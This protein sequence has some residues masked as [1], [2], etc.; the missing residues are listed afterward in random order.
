[1]SRLN[2]IFFT[3]LLISLSLCI[4]QYRTLTLR[5]NFSCT[6]LSA[7]QGD[8]SLI[9]YR[10][11]AI[12][13]DGGEEKNKYS[14]KIMNYLS[15]RHINRI[16]LMVV[17]HAHADHLYGILEVIREIPVD[18]LLIPE[19]EHSTELYQNFKEILQKSSIRVLTAVR[20][21]TLHFTPPL[22]LKVLSPPTPSPFKDIDNNSCVIKINYG[23]TSF[24]FTGD[25]FFEAEQWLCENTKKELK[26]DFL[27]VAHHGS[28]TSSSQAFLKMVNPKVAVISCGI[29]NKFRFPHE[30]A[31]RR[32]EKWCSHLYRTDLQ[33]NI[34]V[35]LKNER[36]VIKTQ[37]S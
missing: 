27:K 36:M 15:D 32:L 11:T 10:N 5:E 17:S 7:G 4:F 9:Q 22:S 26:S 34:E 21:L 8:C 25:I 6:V 18:A 16:Q 28:K 37:Y 30:T 2:K 29:K 20:G 12:L 13:I 31:L 24:L 14:R 35:T 1:M 19:F 23:A 3:F 33:G